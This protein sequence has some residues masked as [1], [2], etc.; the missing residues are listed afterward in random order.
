MV[1]FSESTVLPAM[2]FNLI[3]ARYTSFMKLIKIAHHLLK[4]VC[5]FVKRNT[6]VI[7][8]LL[9]IIHKHTHMSY[10]FKHM[11]YLYILRV[12]V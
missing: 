11:L 5:D 6:V 1:V 10:S 9:H 7:N 3:P 12:Y 2:V 8:V 4:Q